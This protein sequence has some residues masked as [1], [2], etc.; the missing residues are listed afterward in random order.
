[1]TPEGLRTVVE[2]TL[3]LA[4][5]FPKHPEEVYDRVV[6]IAD[7]RL[8]ALTCDRP[9]YELKDFTETVQELE[10]VLGVEIRPFLA[11]NQNRKIEQQVR[12]ATEQLRSI[13]PFNLL[14]NADFLL[15]RL[16]YAM[17]RALKTAVVVE[18]GVAYGVSS[19]F[20]LKALDV[21]GHGRLHSVDL[22]P[23]GQC[24]DRFVGALIPESLKTRWSLY[25]GSSKRVLPPL[26]GQLNELEVFIQ[27]T[28]H[29]YGNVKRELN[30][31]TPFLA[32][33]AVLIADDVGPNKAFLDWV[34]AP[35]P[36]CWAVLREEEKKPQLFGVAAFS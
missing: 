13:G 32:R 6:A 17:C 33:P 26:V 34:G 8:E 10:T 25:R 23:L 11:E 20:A 2:K 16:A 36:D 14:H 15:A 35:Q 9:D 21:N 19:S 3:C 1:M 28:L 29:T 27:N 30:P 22:P 24:A 18:T 5:L 31:V 4:A 7:Y 12:E